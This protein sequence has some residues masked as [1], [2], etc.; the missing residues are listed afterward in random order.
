MRLTVFVARRLAFISLVLVLVSA[1]IFTIAQVLPGDVASMVLGN[2]ATDQDRATLRAKLGMDQ[3]P[4]E[5]YAIWLKGIV[6]GDFGESL[7]MARPI[8]PVL[9]QRLANSTVLAALALLISVP[10]AIAL[11]TLAGVFRERIPDHVISLVTLM[12]V[13][14]PEFVWGNLL[15][16]GLAYWLRLLPPSS[17]LEDDT[18]LANLPAL[19]LPVATLTVVM[20]AHATRMTR[21]SMVEVMRSNYIRSARLKG[22]DERTVVLKH[23]LRNALPPTVTVVAMNIG[24]LMGSLVIVESVFS[25]NGMGRL[26]VF[27]VQNR[28]VPLLEATVL[29][30]AAIYSLS[31]LGADVAYALLNPRIRY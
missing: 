2:E 27:A 23:A 30:L 26:M 15:I 16:F 1:A 25:Y 6:Q 29:V 7:S 10:L 4:A 18:P 9:G 24:W 12:G 21:A 22:L 5:R 14:L 19:V 8:G 31:N 3:P 20:L 28:D 17:L 13:S 11:G